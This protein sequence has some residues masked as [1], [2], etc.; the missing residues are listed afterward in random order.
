MI[1]Q[2]LIRTYIAILERELVPATGCTEPIAL[3]YG[4]AKLRD[5]LGTLPQRVVAQVSWNIIKNVKSV[6]VPNTG[7][8]KG[9]APAVAAGIVAGKPERMMRVIEDVTLPALHQ[10]AVR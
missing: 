4:A 1:D 8:L 7:G 6:V 5:L 9:I 2:T 10:T 3:A